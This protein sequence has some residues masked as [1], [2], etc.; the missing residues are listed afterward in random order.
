MAYD[1]QQ[2]RPENQMTN[3]NRQ[4]L[5]IQQPGEMSDFDREFFSPENWKKAILPPTEPSIIDTISD[6]GRSIWSGIDNAA[7]NTREAISKVPLLG[8][9]IV[10]G[11]DAVDKHVFG[12]GDSEQFL[13]QD[14]QQT[15]SNMTPQ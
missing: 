13:K 4:G 8:G 5:N 15:I 12:N 2:Q 3:N 14:Q 7:L 1:P 9:A 6:T 11:V 10:S